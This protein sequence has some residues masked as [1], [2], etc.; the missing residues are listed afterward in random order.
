MKDIQE[1]IHLE[2]INGLE[3]LSTRKVDYKGVEID[4]FD[5]NSALE[6]SPDVLLVDELPHTNPPRFRHKKRWQDI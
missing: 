2:L 5:L 3:I 1:K 4:E 6:R